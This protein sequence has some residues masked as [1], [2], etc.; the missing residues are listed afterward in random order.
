MSLQWTLVATFLYIE[1]TIVILLLLPIISPRKWQ[2]FF[3]SRFLKSIGNQGNLYFTG[4]LLI[5]I[6]LFLDSIRE[7]RR[8]SF[9]REHD[10]QHGHLNAELAHSMK[11]FRAQR[12]FYIAG[13]ALFLCL[14]IRRIASLI[15][16]TAQLKCELEALTKQAQGASK[17]AEALLKDSKSGSKV[18]G[19]ELMGNKDEKKLLKEIS[20]LKKNLEKAVTEKEAMAKQASGLTKEYDRLAKEHAE[21]VNK[22]ANSD[23]KAD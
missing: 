22:V 7:M 21:L 5:L 2:S 1:I 11:L 9:G 6:L 16:C 3:K 23:K 4:F 14:V 20:E 15:S 18:A 12:N 17:A 8:Y 19:D 10:E 13:F